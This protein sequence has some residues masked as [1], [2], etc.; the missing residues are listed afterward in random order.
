MSVEKAKSK[1]V[2]AP[3][4]LGEIAENYNYYCANNCPFTSVCVLVQMTDYL[5]IMTAQN[6]EDE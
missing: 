2:P 6:E 5:R 4:C 1:R 3:V